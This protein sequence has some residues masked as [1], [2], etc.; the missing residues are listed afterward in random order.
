MLDS[1]VHPGLSGMNSL[2][3]FDEYDLSKVDILLISH[4]HLDHAASLP[5]VMQQT[6]FKGRVFM[7][8]ATKAIYRW[9]LSDFVRVTSM[10]GGGDEA[11]QMDS[12]QQNGGGSANLYTN[13]DLMSSFEK[14]ETIDYH[15]TIEVDGIRFTAYHAGHVLGA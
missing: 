11:R 12:S 5:Y 14:I 4:F 15:S 10:V 2:P 6:S 9:L 3:F 8:H 1:G 7:T 13:E